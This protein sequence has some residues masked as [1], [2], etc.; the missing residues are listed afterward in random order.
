MRSS[1]NNV[2]CLNRFWELNRLHCVIL[3]IRKRSP[4][5]ISDK[6]EPAIPWDAAPEFAQD[7]NHTSVDKCRHELR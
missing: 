1:A 4:F 2:N 7:R 5:R 3:D 6:D